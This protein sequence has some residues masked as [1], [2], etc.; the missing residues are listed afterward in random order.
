MEHRD[1]PDSQRHEPK[2]ASSAI[3]GTFYIS[4]GS[5]SGNW[6]KLRADN[7]EGLGASVA[8]GRLIT[9]TG[10]GVFGSRAPEF[11]TDEI[12]YDSNPLTD[13]IDLLLS[14]IARLEGLIQ[15]LEVRI[16]DLETAE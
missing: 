12:V 3:Q 10:G 13:T 8:S 5:G 9:S 1:I 7:V 2:G 16:E 11:D 14:E 6:T 4:N 15:G